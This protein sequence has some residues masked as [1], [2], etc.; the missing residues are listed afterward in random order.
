[1]SL[2]IS[3]AASL[4]KTIVVPAPTYHSLSDMPSESRAPDSVTALPLITAVIVASPVRA[5]VATPVSV[6]TMLLPAPLAAV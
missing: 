6:I 4:V 3:L 2:S 5:V 1:M